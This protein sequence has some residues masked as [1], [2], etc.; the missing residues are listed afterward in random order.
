MLTL[1]RA[2]V[3]TAASSFSVGVDESDSVDDL[4]KAIK[5]EK[6]N[7]ITC[8]ADELQCDIKQALPRRNVMW[9]PR[10][11]DAFAKLPRALWYQPALDLAGTPLCDAL[12]RLRREKI[13]KLPT[14]WA[15]GVPRD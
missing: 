13:D 5:A 6:P 9:L 15:A 3:G 14:E 12:R 1:F 11:V 8:D 2:L 4:K 10:W 7:T